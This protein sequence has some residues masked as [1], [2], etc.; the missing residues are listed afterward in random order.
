[1]RF[2]DRK[3]AAADNEIK[4]QFFNSCG[5]I[6]GVTRAQHVL[7]ATWHDGDFI[8]L[9]FRC[10]HENSVAALKAIHERWLLVRPGAWEVV[11]TM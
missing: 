3:V 7:P 11:H 5:P 1:M 2:G 9:F 6:N 8:P 4:A 10:F